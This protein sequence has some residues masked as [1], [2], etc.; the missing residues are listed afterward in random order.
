MEG[1]GK[2]GIGEISFEDK[3]FLKMMIENS[4]KFWKHYEVPL[5][6]KNPATK[7]P[8]NRYLAEKRLLSLKKRFLKDP[9]FF[10]DYNG[11]V[12]ELID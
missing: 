3:E 10:S 2:T 8:N 12:E 5:P 6:L 1:I 11:F 9:N 7:L 4:R